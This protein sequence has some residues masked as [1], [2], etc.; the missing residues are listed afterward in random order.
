M[1]GYAPSL[2]YGIV[3]QT[4]STLMSFYIWSKGCCSLLTW[5]LFVNQ[6]YTTVRPMIIL[7][8]QI[9]DHDNATV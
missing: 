2:V 4:E 7:S 1:D 3:S 6:C 8:A 5:Q 9:L